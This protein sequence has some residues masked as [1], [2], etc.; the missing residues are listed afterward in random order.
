M[1]T[2]EPEQP[3]DVYRRRLAARRATAERLARVDSGISWSRLAVFVALR[4]LVWLVLKTDR[5]GAPWLA[6]PVGRSRFSS[7][8]TIARARRAGGASLRRR[9][10]SDRRSA[11]LRRWTQ[12]PLR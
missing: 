5:L 12:R 4:A 9:H 10:R 2:P 1:S 11:A 8:C 7:S 6:V 3:V